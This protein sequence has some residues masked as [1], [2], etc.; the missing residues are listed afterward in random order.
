MVRTKVNY[1]LW[2]RSVYQF[3]KHSSSD[4]FTTVAI[5][6]MK[7][8]SSICWRVYYTSF[9]YFSSPTT[10]CYYCCITEVETLPS[11][12]NYYWNIV[13]KVIL[14]RGIAAEAVSVGYFRTRNWRIV[15]SM[16]AEKL[17]VPS[18]RGSLHC[19]LYCLSS[20]NHHDGKYI[21]SASLKPFIFHS[22]TSRVEASR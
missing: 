20:L 15:A 13:S 17:A 12:V 2:I 14:V 7:P 10:S 22:K 6:L 9:H 18:L 3:L 19:F 16:M 4:S 11:W 1:S 5:F 21:F 8:P